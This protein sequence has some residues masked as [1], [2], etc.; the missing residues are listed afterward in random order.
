MAARRSNF[1]KLELD[2][3]GGLTLQEYAVKSIEKFSAADHWRT[4]WLTTAEL[5]TTAPPPPEL[6]T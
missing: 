2:P 3:K 4:G 5:A 1:D 6:K